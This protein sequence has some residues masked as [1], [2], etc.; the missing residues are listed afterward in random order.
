MKKYL[1]NL[2]KFLLPT[3]LLAIALEITVRRIPNDYSYKADYLEQNSEEI[4]LL[5]LGNSHCYYGVNPD[6]LT[7]IS[8]NAAYVSQTIN[9]NFFIFD[10]YK[11]LMKNLKYVIFTISYPSLLSKLEDSKESWRVVN[12]SIYYDNNYHY[13]SPENNFEILGKSFKMNISNVISYIKGKD[14]ITCSKL[15]YGIDKL[16]AKQA[17]LTETG[18]S[19]AK[20]HTKDNLNNLKGNLTFLKRLINR[21]SEEKV[22]VILFTPPA[23][24]YYRKNLDEEQLLQMQNEC[25]KL[26]NQNN[27]VSYY[28]FME[29]SSF[30]NGDFRDADHLNYMGA[31]KLTRLL[32]EI[33]TEKESL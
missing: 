15:G 6:F 16:K 10:K 9:Y 26:E 23:H 30:G 25:K 20:R 22:Q 18:K 13:L 29:S 11:P 7:P 27:N 33:I 4:K 31:G 17:D 21:C 14:N 2:L 32:N 3:I 1:V 24:K 28:N 12:Y 8:F 19:A 5:L